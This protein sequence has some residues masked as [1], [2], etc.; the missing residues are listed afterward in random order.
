ML[1]LI[2]V[3][4]C[5]Q[6]KNTGANETIYIQESI[7]IQTK[8]FIPVNTW[9]FCLAQ[10]AGTAPD[11][12]EQAKLL[13]KMSQISPSWEEEAKLLETHINKTCIFFSLFLLVY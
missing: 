8:Q 12:E 3:R 10:G 9:T 1:S 6:I 11:L 2:A 4:Q 7:P 5:K 13:T